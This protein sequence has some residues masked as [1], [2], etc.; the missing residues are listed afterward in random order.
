[1]VNFPAIKEDIITA[2][3]SLPKVPCPVSHFFAPGIYV[4]EMLIPAGTVAIGHCH[5]AEHLCTLLFG[6]AVFY[7]E[8]EKPVKLTGPTTFL[9]GS[10]HKV[11]YA[12]TDIRV[13]N[14]YPNPYDI[15]DQDSLESIYVEKTGMFAPKSIPAIDHGRPKK[16]VKIDNAVD[17]P[18]G[19][20]TAITIRDSQIHG[21]GVFASWPFAPGEYIAPYEIE[22][23]PTI[24]AKYINHSDQNNCMVVSVTG[25]EKIIVSLV[26]IV[27]DLGDSRGQELTVNYEAIP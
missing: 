26:P 22:G 11:V 7:K 27:G 6:I 24:V 9:S 4:R 18:P 8:N 25:G 20:E 14:C 13:Q 5:K 17:L 21:K 23:Q 16:A 1:M 3:E 12:L 10:G 2:V 15:R 19:F